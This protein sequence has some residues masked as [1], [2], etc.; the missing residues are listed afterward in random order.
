MSSFGAMSSGYVFA[1]PNIKEALSN[2]DATNLVDV[3]YEVDNFVWP[4]CVEIVP[5][6]VFNEHA[7]HVPDGFLVPMKTNGGIY[8]I[9]VD[10]NDPTL[11][12]GKVQISE[13]K[14]GF[15][16]HMGSWVDMNGDGRKD[17]L[18]ARS[19]SKAG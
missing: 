2:A 10:D 9:R 11:A 19:N 7:I 5:Y 8:I 14:R 15:Y 17:F 6:D 16:Y 18:T 1:V 3:R 13:K 12:T 4:N